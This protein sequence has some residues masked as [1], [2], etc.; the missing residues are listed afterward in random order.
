MLSRGRLPIAV[1]H[2]RS[3]GNKEL[4]QCW[5][6]STTLAESGHRPNPP[7]FHPLLKS[8]FLD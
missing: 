8:L 7:T 5:L 6:K 3:R 4:S 2:V 1:K